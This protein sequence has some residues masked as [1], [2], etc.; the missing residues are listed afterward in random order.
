MENSL[1]NNKSIWLISIFTITIFI[2]F[3]SSVIFFGK[4]ILAV[5]LTLLSVILVLLILLKG[6]SYLMRLVSFIFKI[7]YKSAGIIMALSLAGWLLSF[8]L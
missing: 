4:F 6:F 8:F 3:I 5:T 1:K 2:A 7:G